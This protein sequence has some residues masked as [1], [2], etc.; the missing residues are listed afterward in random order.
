[1][2]VNLVEKAITQKTKAIVPVHFTGYMTNMKKINKIANK[3]KLVVVEDACQSI[4]ASQDGKIAGNWGATGCFSLH[5]LKNLN[6]WSDGGVIITKNSKLN[7]KLRLLR[8]HGLKSR[9]KVEIMGFNSRLDTI[10]AVVGNW[11]IP[12][13]KKISKPKN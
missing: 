9:D 13:T 3:H 5:P 4:L 11:L 7:S 2:N 12:Q 8:N 6:V 1:M 10:Q